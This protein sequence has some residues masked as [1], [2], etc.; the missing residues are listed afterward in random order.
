[1]HKIILSIFALS[2]SLTINA[3]SASEAQALHDK[4]KQCVNEGKI[5]EGRG[6][7][8][9]AL[10]MRKK[11]FGEVNEDYITSL[12]N[13]ALSFA[14]EN[15]Y[16]NAVKYQEQAMRLCDKLKEKQGKPHK[17]YGLYALNM[18]RFYYLSDDIV[19]AATYWEKAL[20]CVV[21]Y[22]EMYENLLQWL[23]MIYSDR[24]DNGNLQRIMA[25]TEDHNQHE[26]SKECNEP[27]CMLGRANY[28]AN[29]G[30]TAKAKECFMQVLSMKM[31]DEMKAKVYEDYSIFLAKNM[32]W[33]SA[34]DYKILSANL[35][36]KI[37]GKK[38]TYAQQLLMAGMCYELGKKY[39][40][41][42]EI[43]NSAI[44]CYQSLA[45]NTPYDNSASTNSPLKK[46]ADCQ[47]GIGNAYSAMK[48]YAKAC[49]A[50]KQQMA[51]YEQYDKNSEEYPK[52]IL[53]LGK[54]EKFNKDYESSI[55][56]HKKAMQLFEEKGM[57]Q[58]Y[59]NA[60]SSLKL[61]YFYAGKTDE[62]DYKDDAMLRERTKKLDDIIKDE[63]GNLQMTLQ[64]LGKLT[65]ARSLATIAGCYAMKE[66][67]TNAITYYKQYI[68][69]I[70]DAIREEFR[71]QSE[72]E[73]M[74][75]WQEEANNILALMGLLTVI[76]QNNTALYSELS[77][78]A[79]DAALLSKGILLNSSIEFEKVIAQHGDKKLKELYEQTKSISNEISNLRQNAKSDA[80]LQKILTLSQKNQT[81]QLQLYKQCAEFADFTNYISYNWQD[82]QKQLSATDIAIEFA[83]TK[84]GVMDDENIMEAIILTN[85]GSS[86]VTIPICTLDEA[87]KIFADD[88]VYDL[89]NNIVWGKIRNYLSGKKRIFFSADDIFNN[90]GIEYLVYDGKPLSEQM[91]V[92]R[93]STTKVLCYHQ[94][95]ALT[96]NAVLFGDINYNE[97]GTVSSSAKREMA[98]LRGSGDVSMFGNLDN[99]KREINEIEQVLKKGSIKKVVSLSDQNASKQA[100]LNLTDKKLNILHIATHGAYR[101]QKGMSDQEAM[102]SS[103]LAFAGANLDEQGIVTAAEVAKMNLRE[104]DIVALSACET[105]LGKLGTDGVFGLQRGFKNAGV[106]TLL[107]SLKNVYDTSTA[108]LMISFYN[109]LMNGMS[110]R[111]ALKK[112]QQDVRA[113][114][115]KDAKYWASFILLDALD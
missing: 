21:K 71:M 36:K 52:A 34:G 39:E 86:P 72:S 9:Q 1:M 95:P 73:R 93:L 88:K 4:G 48:D 23:A 113:K 61:C 69:A 82:V 6:Y 53:R 20:P 103:I 87:K 25:L 58:E 115:Y 101:P 110:K 38:A 74:H 10:D 105:G 33:N 29:K 66:D 8:K 64:Y 67:Y 84:I 77:A 56:H 32:E 83:A 102:S 13:Y 2:L 96:N 17:N 24:K 107:M 22:S 35:N 62:V 16:A 42:I 109:Y 3:Q 44:E 97:E 47:K 7:T 68:E 106:H 76:P 100:F 75:T 112:A 81:L 43:Y 78:I 99:T 12:N 65:Y 108:E 92:Y 80:D 55:A 98:G 104:C 60:A 57:A 19:G 14:L 5:A 37:Q 70:R 41:A 90:V 79:Y 40:V 94:Q 51:Y 114:G 31:D 26:L 63:T 18:G 11:L 91:E 59:T 27:K 85:D 111:E 50:F 45:T 30:N 46:I 28:Y 49:D 54:A 89:S 15:D